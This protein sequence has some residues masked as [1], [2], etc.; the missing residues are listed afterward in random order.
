MD[1]PIL[2]I[3]PDGDKSPRFGPV[4]R[5]D[6]QP[7]H[8]C[9]RERRR[10]FPE[11][12]EETLS[13]GSRLSMNAHRQT[14]PKIAKKQYENHQSQHNASGAALFFFLGRYSG[15]ANDSSMLF[16]AAILY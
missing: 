14:P 12:A 6:E 8:I 15:M 16:D 5:G 1:P 3:R 13:G 7:P 4:L 2:R 9:C 10:V 11:A